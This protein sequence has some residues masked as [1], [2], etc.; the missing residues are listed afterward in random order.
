M[1]SLI[2]RLHVLIEAQHVSDSDE[3][4]SYFHFLPFLPK[5]SSKADR[6][7]LSY[8]EYPLEGGRV[9]SLPGKTG[10][11]RKNIGRKR[12]M[13]KVSFRKRE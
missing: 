5:Q 10:K 3:T 4:V 6:L 1:Q 11:R 9:V 2:P 7:R 12:K 13:L 8:L